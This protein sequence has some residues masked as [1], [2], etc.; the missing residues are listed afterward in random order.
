TGVAVDPTANVTV[1]AGCTEALASAFLG[2]IDA[3]D[4]V[5]LFQPYYDSYRACVAMAGATPRFVTLRPDFQ[6]GSFV[7]DEAELRAAFTPR[8]R[9]I[10][11]NT[12]HNPTGKVFSRPELELIASLCIE[13][14]A[15]AI[16][17]EVY[18]RLVYEPEHP[19]HS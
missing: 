4:E 3:G 6:A 19:H 16:T 5:I 11:V 12:P 7:F 13:H 17:D 2:L 15:V 9:A 10:L 18:E 14:D 8:T 1:T